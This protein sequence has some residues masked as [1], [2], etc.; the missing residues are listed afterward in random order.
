MSEGVTLGIELSQDSEDFLV[1][2]KRLKEHLNF[3]HYLI[4]SS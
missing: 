3:S 2:N 1:L 4:S